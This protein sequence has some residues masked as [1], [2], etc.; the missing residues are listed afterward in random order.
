MSGFDSVV[1]EPEGAEAMWFA[2]KGW[3]SSW[4]QSPCPLRRCSALDAVTISKELLL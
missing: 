2:G 3:R 4:M 1:D